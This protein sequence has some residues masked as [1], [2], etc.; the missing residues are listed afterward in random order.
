M[1]PPLAA[2]VAP[3]AMAPPSLALPHAHGAP[4]QGL[5]QRLPWI[6]VGAL[7]VAVAALLAYIVI[8]GV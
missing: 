3:G 6:L 1:A 4:R 7:G 8:L 5:A 2:P